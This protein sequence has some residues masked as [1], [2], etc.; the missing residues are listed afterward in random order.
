MTT[1]TSSTSPLRMPWTTWPA[2][3]YRSPIGWRRDSQRGTVGG[4][5]DDAALVLVV[6]SMKRVVR[7]RVAIIV[8]MR[9]VVLVA[10]RTM[11]PW[12]ED[13]RPDQTPH[14]DH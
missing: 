9:R 8:E 4:V 13:P 12:P 2:G 5:R 7:Q 6:A 3:W 10:P 14:R 1:S 11:V